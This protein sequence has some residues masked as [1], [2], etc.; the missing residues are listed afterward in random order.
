LPSERIAQVNEII[1]QDRLPVSRP[2]R[3]FR[4]EYEISSSPANAGD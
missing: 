3:Q 1:A 4:L 2:L